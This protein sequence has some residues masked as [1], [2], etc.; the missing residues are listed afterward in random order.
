MNLV[1]GECLFAELYDQWCYSR[2][3]YCLG[4]RR[5]H[6]ATPSRALADTSTPS[7]CGWNITP[8]NAFL[9]R[10]ITS[11]SVAMKNDIK[12]TF[13]SKKGIQTYA[14]IRRKIFIQFIFESA[15]VV[16]NQHIRLNHSSRPLYVCYL[17]SYSEVYLAVI[18]YK[19]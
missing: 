7:C 4:E 10:D 3:T 12:T 2:H 5:S 19:D 11:D 1:A 14:F 6:S 15:P 17:P 13:T 16:A 9:L 8:W 18:Q